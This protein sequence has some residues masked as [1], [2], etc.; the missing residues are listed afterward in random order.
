MVMLDT[1]PPVEN[2]EPALNSRVSREVARIVAAAA[3]KSGP[4]QPAR[5]EIAAW[6]YRIPFAGV[7]YYG[8]HP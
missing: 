1:R 3:E 7:R 2:P 5:P 8:Y 4:A 6:S